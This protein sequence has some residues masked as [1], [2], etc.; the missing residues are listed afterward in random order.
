MHLAKKMSLEASQYISDHAP[1]TLE[2]PNHEL[3]H[4][5]QADHVMSLHGNLMGYR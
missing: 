3:E 1:A 2:D 5:H 4:Q